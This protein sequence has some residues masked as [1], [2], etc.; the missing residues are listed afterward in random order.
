M[1]YFAYRTTKDSEGNTITYL[2]TSDDPIRQTSDMISKEEAFAR[3]RT[4]HRESAYAEDG[5]M[6]VPSVLA[7]TAAE[8]TLLKNYVRPGWEPPTFIEER[9]N[10]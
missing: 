9:D 3:A 6:L 7:M 8:E 4:N 10:A 1:E 2:V 5:S